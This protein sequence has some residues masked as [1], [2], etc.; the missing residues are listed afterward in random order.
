MVT[1]RNVIP[2]RAGVSRLARYGTV[3]TYRAV[4]QDP[5]LPTPGYPPSFS[6]SSGRAK[7]H[8]DGQ[9]LILPLRRS[10]QGLLW[11]TNIHSPDQAI[12][13]RPATTK[14]TIPERWR[15]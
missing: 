9:L 14:A 3:P 6:R 4:H 2:Y 1:P 13:L 11:R 15:R 10:S 8:Y 7:A 5:G 12:E